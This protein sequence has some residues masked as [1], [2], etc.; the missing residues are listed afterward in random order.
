M[1]LLT[2]LWGLNENTS[3]MTRVSMLAIVITNITRIYCYNYKVPNS[4]AKKE[5]L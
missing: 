5:S 3:K 2:V 4:I 1:P